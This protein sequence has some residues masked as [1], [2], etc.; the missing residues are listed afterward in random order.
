[1]LWIPTSAGMT[2]VEGRRLGVGIVPSATIAE[3]NIKRCRVVFFN[4]LNTSDFLHCGIEL[5]N[6]WET[7]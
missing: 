3:H 7:K 5:L 4:S 2:V 1:M 6:P